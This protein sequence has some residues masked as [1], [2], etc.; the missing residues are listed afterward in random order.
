MLVC[1]GFYLG[2]SK[3]ETP[4]QKIA[5]YKWAYLESVLKTHPFP[6]NSSNSTFLV[7]AMKS[8]YIMYSCNVTKHV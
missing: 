2:V 5:E 7:C 4:F 8:Q 6:L 1:T 3:K